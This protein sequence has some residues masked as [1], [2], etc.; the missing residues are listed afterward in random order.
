MILNVLTVFYWANGN[1]N[2]TMQHE[3]QNWFAIDTWPGIE[4]EWLLSINC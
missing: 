3:V 2:G 4:G 1:R